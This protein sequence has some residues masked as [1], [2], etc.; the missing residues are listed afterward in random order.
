ME[1]NYDALY[2]ITL[3]RRAQASLLNQVYFDKVL[4]A[5]EELEKLRMA[6]A[7]MICEHHPWLPWPHNECGGPGCPESAGVGIMQQR[8]RT[9]QIAVQM[10]DT[11]VC[12]LYRHIT[13]G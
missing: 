12:D 6:S 7:E 5:L 11:M 13:E 2:D 8:V 3:K 9:L 4:E 1:T 10:R